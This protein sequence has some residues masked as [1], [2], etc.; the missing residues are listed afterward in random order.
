MARQNVQTSEVWSTSEVSDSMIS[1]KRPNIMPISGP[2]SFVPTLNLFLPH[3]VDVNLA[4]GGGGPLVLE[5]GT[6]IAILTGY[7]AGD[8]GN[9]MWST[10]K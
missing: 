6:T 3:W 2:S 7:R 4:L 10:G 1:T 8:A 9:F 5:D